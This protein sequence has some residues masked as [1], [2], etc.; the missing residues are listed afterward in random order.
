MRNLVEL[1]AAVDSHE[2][3]IPTTRV[4]THLRHDSPMLCQTSQPLSRAAQRRRPAA[5]C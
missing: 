5:A 1:A 2:A 4:R 3:G